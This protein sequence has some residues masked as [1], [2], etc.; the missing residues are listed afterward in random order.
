MERQME[1]IK[2][3]WKID[4][5]I[6][7]DLEAEDLMAYLIIKDN[8]KE[9]STSREFNWEQF[10]SVIYKEKIEFIDSSLQDITKI[11][12]LKEWI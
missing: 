5:D 2:G 8:P 11:F 6:F 7:E 9:E 10:Y 12:S 1:T 3:R 4:I